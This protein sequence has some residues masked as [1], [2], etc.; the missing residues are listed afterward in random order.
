MKYALTFSV[1]AVSAF[2]FG[3]CALQ[4]SPTEAH[5]QAL[6]NPGAF[7]QLEPQAA[8]TTYYVAGTGND[9]NN[10]LSKRA[11][12]RTLQRAADLTQPGDTVWVMNGLYTRDQLNSVVLEISRSGEP[13]N[14]IQ[15]KAFPGQHP[16]IKLN[17]NFAGIQI[18]A[19][20]VVIEGFT[21]EGDIPSIPA[22]EALRRAL[23]P[24]DQVVEA[25]RE[26][27][28][29]GGGI[30]AYPVNG[31]FPH[32]LIIR[33]NHV[34][35][36]PGTG[37]SSNGSDYI[38]IENNLVHNNS[39]YNPNATSGISF[40]QSRDID[41]FTG[42]K[43]FVRGNVTYRNENKVPFW[44]SNSDPSKRRITDGNGIIIDDNR[45]TQTAGGTP[46][47][48]KTVIENN[49]AYDNGGRGIN[50]FESDNIEIRNNT[51]YK[52]ARA[53]STAIGSEFA[54]GNVSSTQVVHNLMVARPDRQVVKTYNTSDVTFTDNLFLGGNG[55]D[56]FPAGVEGNVRGGGAKL[57]SARAAQLRHVQKAFAKAQ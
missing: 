47:Q 37:I 2:M 33:K 6:N 34:F 45:S 50:I 31:H 10:G 51:T 25:I 32:H 56:E 19:A 9:A 52:N 27:P 43:I 3:G 41:D 29:R 16:R 30:F 7:A 46:Y 35:N 36:C 12:F 42:A 20:Y 18:S 55:E 40:Y 48:G 1:L 8:D 14:Y 44:Y 22:E 13:D 53:V 11:A 57:E 17:R 28:F 4:D 39:Y 21:V 26:S 54:L 38:R 23:L 5:L 49:L 24:A 15:Y